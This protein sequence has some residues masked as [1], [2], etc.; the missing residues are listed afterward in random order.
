MCFLHCCTSSS[1]GCLLATVLLL[2]RRRAQGE[3]GIPPH[4]AAPPAASLPNGV[5]GENGPTAPRGAAGSVRE[6]VQRSLFCTPV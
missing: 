4:R 5:P 1:T 3:V 6:Q 2:K